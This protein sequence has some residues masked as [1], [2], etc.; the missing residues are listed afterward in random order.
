MKHLEWVE[1]ISNT[2]LRHG[3]GAHV[4]LRDDGWYARRASRSE[5]RGC[6]SMAEAKAWALGEIAPAKPRAKSPKLSEKR[7]PHDP[8]NPT[9]KEYQSLPPGWVKTGK[10]E[11]EHDNGS[12]V[13]RKGTGYLAKDPEGES[14]TWQARYDAF[15]WGQ[16]DVE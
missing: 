2:W 16:G 13:K 14:T 8:F 6:A 15:L 10:D 7:R 11:W 9:Q 1:G 3:S 5:R 4:S 12:T